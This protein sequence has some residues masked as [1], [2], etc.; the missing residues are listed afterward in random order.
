M[1]TSDHDTIVVGTSSGGV[2]A[3]AKLLGGLPGELYASVLIVL[4]TSPESPQLSPTSSR[5]VR[6]SGLR[7]GSTDIPSNEGTST[8]RLLATI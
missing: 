7:T 3:L 4:H 2:A 5:D 1:T 6:H 8:S